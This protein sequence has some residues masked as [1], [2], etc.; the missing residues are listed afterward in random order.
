MH[1][2]STLRLIGFHWPL[3][4]APSNAK[5]LTNIPGELSK[6]DSHWVYSIY[7]PLTMFLYYKL[8]KGCLDYE[9]G[10]VQQI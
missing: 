1:T 2:I 3:N 7:Y 6:K 10:A 5:M 8:E 4:L 9:P